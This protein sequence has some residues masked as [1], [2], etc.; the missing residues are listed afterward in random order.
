MDAGDVAHHD[1]AGGAGTQSTEAPPRAP[2]V[3]D[4]APRA[5][6]IDDGS[7]PAHAGGGAG[8]ATSD[9]RRPPQVHRLLVLFGSQTGSAEDLAHRVARE[10]SRRGFLPEVKAM[11]AFDRADLVK[12]RLVI[13]LAATAGD[14]ACPDNMAEFWTFLRRKDLPAGALAAMKFTVFGLGDS[15]YTQYNAAARRLWV[16]L[17]ALGAE[18]FHER[19]L[20]DDNSDFGLEGGFRPWMQSVWT[21]LLQ[22]FPIPTGCVVDD[23]PQRMRA[24]YAV[25]SGGAP[26]GATSTAPLIT[27]TAAVV[28]TSEPGVEGPWSAATA[29]RVDP[30]RLSLPFFKAPTGALHGPH[31]DRPQL[32]LGSLVENTRLTAPDWEQDVRQI[33]IDISDSGIEYPAGSVVVLHPANTSSDDGELIRRLCRRLHLSPSLEIEIRPLTEAEELR[34][35]AADATSVPCASPWVPFPERC[36]VGEL[37]GW[38]LDIQGTPRKDFFE[39]LAFYT[40]DE[41]EVDRLREIAAPDGADLYHNYCYRERRTFVE[42]LEDF[43]SVRVPLDALLDLVPP[44]KPREYSIASSAL[45]HP[46]QVQLCMAVV[47]YRTPWKRPKLGVC[48]SWLAS[49]DPTNAPLIPLWIKPSPLRLPDVRSDRAPPL[50]LIGPGTGVAPM[51]SLL[52]ERQVLLTRDA[53]AAGASEHSAAHDVDMDGGG[54]G[55]DDDS[56]ASVWEGQHGTAALFFGCRHH[57]KDYYFKAQWERMRRLG[58]AGL[59]HLATAFSRDQTKKIYVQHKLAESR[60][61]VF[62]ALVANAGYCFIAGSAKRMVSD[63]TTVLKGIC[64]KEGGMSEKEAALLVSRLHKTGHI[65]IEAWS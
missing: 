5:G 9:S 45:A 48:S 40:D 29:L 44:Q 54:A 10:G 24:R 7:S 12:E 39:Q 43:P 37:F 26:L 49:L 59:S 51:R 25:L 64:V 2:A 60:G 47:Q 30:R 65:V 62:N 28:N 33:T 41:D 63:V 16:R 58:D 8:T 13:F 23:T 4:P 31:A 42:V 3:A 34:S 50:L 27:P 35:I 1:A 18:P 53:G 57:D 61:A 20:G 46:G 36:S 22:M 52:E 55:G 17:K 32:T 21:R 56:P 19:G 14:G 38:Y 15:S 6:P 11:D